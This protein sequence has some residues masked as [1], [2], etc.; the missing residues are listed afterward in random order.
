MRKNRL[1]FSISINTL[2]IDAALSVGRFLGFSLGFKGFKSVDGWVVG[3][4]IDGSLQ[5]KY[6]SIKYILF[7]INI[8]SI[9]RGEGFAF[10]E[11]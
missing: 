2:T 1:F 6:I 10:R 4:I 9:W 11:T 3:V 5:I 7:S 8:Y